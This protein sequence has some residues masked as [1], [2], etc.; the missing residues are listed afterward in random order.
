MGTIYYAC[1]CCEEESPESAVFRRE[2]VRVIPGGDW[3]CET[4]FDDAGA[5]T[6]VARP[7]GIENPDPTDWRDLPEVPEHVPAPGHHEQ[8]GTG[9]E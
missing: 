2:D 9:R 4:C 6:Y 1:K 8:S 5:W 3:I 7:E